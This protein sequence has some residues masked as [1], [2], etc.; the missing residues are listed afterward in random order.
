[1]RIIGLDIHRAFAEAVALEDGVC[2]RL[3]RI[4]MTRDQLEAFAETL[5]STDHVVVEST[6]NATAV[7]DILAPKVARVAVANP[8]QVH[9]I[10]LPRPRPTRS[11]HGF[12]QSSTPPDF[13]PRSGFR[14]QRRRPGG[15]RS[16]AGTSW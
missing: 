5:Q 12:W 14:T 3:G 15:G 8:L 9:L 11:M 7:L 13:C 2:R 6:G 16:R 10:A 4:G 1:M